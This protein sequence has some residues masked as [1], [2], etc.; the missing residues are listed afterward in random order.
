MKYNNEL[1][2]IDNPEKAYLLGLFYSDGYVCST[3]NNCGITLHEQDIL[4]LE[5]LIDLFPFFKIR[6]SHKCAYKIDCTSK[7]LKKDLIKNGVLPLKSSINKEGLSIKK[8]LNENLF[9][10]FIRG[11][12]DGDGSVYKQKLFNIKIE[13]GCTS[14]SFISELVKI[15]Y[16]NKINV[17]LRC[18]F[19]G[20]GLRTFDYY[21][22]YTSSYKTSKL[23]SNFIYNESTIHLE[24]KFNLLNLEVRYEEKERLQCPICNSYNTFYQGFRNYKTRIKCK[25]CNK[26]STIKT[27]PNS[28]NTISGEDELLEV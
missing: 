11:F 2:I 5:K 25:D 24:R 10:H 15:L 9:S 3:N 12:F 28:S 7:D 16:D 6:K 27:A 26:G 21:K 23:F 1:Q 14:F 4:L 8:I 18:S 17:N 13:I 19:L 20:A 22:L